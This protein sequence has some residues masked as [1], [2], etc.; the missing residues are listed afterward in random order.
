MP[1]NLDGRVKPGHPDHIEEYSFLLL[2]GPI[3]S[4]HDKMV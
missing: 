2:D 3:K 1:F 4:G